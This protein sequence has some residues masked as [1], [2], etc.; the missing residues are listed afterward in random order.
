[1]TDD[2]RGNPDHPL[3]VPDEPGERM[4]E[5]AYDDLVSRD[6]RAIAAHG[7]RRIRE[8][9]EK[10]RCDGEARWAAHQMLQQAVRDKDEEIRRLKAEL[11]S[12]MT[13]AYPKEPK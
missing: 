11:Y 4:R 9:R 5:S 1:M 12:A 7:E 10:L 8:R 2:I 3:D 6:V 13:N